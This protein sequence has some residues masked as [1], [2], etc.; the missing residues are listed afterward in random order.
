ME[1]FRFIRNLENFVFYV[2][3]HFAISNDD[4]SALK[5]TFPKCSFLKDK[6]SVFNYSSQAPGGFEV[7]LE[8]RKQSL[9]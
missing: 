6:I 9:I 1:I 4:F 2:T 8:E 7:I 5:I 3:L